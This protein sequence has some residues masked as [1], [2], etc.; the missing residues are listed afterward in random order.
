MAATEPDRVFEV[1]EDGS[2]APLFGPPPVWLRVL[3]WLA[4]AAVWLGVP[5]TLFGAAL[6]IGGAL[7]WDWPVRGVWLA[8]GGFLGVWFADRVAPLFRGV[9][10]RR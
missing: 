8:V 4:G 5:L 10:Q 1:D 6:A 3:A 9:R 7:G 2:V